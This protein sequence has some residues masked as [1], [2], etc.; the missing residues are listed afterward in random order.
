MQDLAI[1]EAILRNRQHFFAEIRDG[2]GLGDKMRALL[3]S[4]IV[5][6]ALYGGGLGLTHSPE[7]TL[8]SAIKLP[9]LFLVTLAVCT[10][11]LYF[12][13]VLYGSNQ[14]L[15]QNFVLVLTAIA[16]TSVLLLSFAPIVIFFI[17]TTSSYQFLE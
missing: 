13:N 5:F 10:P 2:I 12:F 9:M 17:L 6:L 4:S 3:I 11:T 15:T 8:S 16:V 14:S 7:Q 1:I